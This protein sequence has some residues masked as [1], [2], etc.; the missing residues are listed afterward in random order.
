MLFL[1][2]KNIGLREHI[3]FLIRTRVMITLTAKVLSRLSASLHM[4]W[5]TTLLKLFLLHRWG[6]PSSELNELC[7]VHR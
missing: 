4:V 1:E 2:G 3:S 7:K 6:T 5:A